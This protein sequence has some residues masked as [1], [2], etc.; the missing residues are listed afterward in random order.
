MKYLLFLFL[1]LTLSLS[2]QEKSNYKDFRKGTFVYEGV[3]DVKLIRTKKK[4]VEIFNDGKSKIT[5]SIKWEN[6]STYVLTVTEILNSPGCLHVGDVI[7]TKITKR[8][9]PKFFF[10]YQ[11]ANCG[12]GA[13]ELIKVK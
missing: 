4:Q 9:G 8:E 3:D 5:M 1:L 2:A 6:D 13:G 7:Y 11:T 12:N 10:S